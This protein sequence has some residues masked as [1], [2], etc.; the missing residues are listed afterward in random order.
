MLLSSQHINMGFNF[1]ANFGLVCLLQIYQGN[2]YTCLFMF[3]LT[4]N[5]LCV[6]ARRDRDDIFH[7]AIEE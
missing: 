2:L 5:Y 6:I 1:I 4:N 7:Q 3:D